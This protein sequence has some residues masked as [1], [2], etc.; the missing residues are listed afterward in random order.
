MLLALALPPTRRTRRFS[1]D[2]L[3]SP[4]RNFRV[5]G[6]AAGGARLVD[7]CKET[8]GAEKGVIKMATCRLCGDRYKKSVMERHE[9]EGCHKRIVRCPH[10]CG[11]KMRVEV[12]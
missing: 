7:L 12:L 9:R 3:F 2:S 8:K 4:L 5:N 6:G 1:V 11:E 10:R